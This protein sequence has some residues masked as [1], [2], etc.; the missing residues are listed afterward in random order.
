MF[1]RAE[2]TE[3]IVGFG[4]DRVAASSEDKGGSQGTAGSA[5]RNTSELGTPE[6]V[7]AGLSH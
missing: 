3:G 2:R 1:E 4:I 7:P 6:P 5:A